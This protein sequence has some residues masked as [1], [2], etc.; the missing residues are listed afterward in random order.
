MFKNR[1]RIVVFFYFSGYADRG[2][3]EQRR[4]ESYRYFNGTKNFFKNCM[5]KNDIILVLKLFFPMGFF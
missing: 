3:V 1:M 2:G 4:A 5:A